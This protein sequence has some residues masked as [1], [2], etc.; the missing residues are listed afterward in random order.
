MILA[1]HQR[2][3]VGVDG[4]PNSAAAARWAANVAE[5][6]NAPLHIASAV[7]EPTFYIAESAMVIP[8]EVWE[9]QRH[10]ADKLVAD[11]S[12]A[13]Q[14]A[15]PSLSVTTGVDTTSAAVMLV[16]HSRTARVV[17]VGNS[18]TGLLVSTL[19]GS[20]AKRT[21]DK[22]DCPVV[23]WR[24]GDAAVDAPIVV[25]VD[26]SATSAAAVEYAF[27]LAAGLGLP[28]IAVHTWNAFSLGGGVALPG[29]VD[30]TTLE[31]EESALLSESLAGWSQKY[32]EVAVEHV[33]RQGS[34]A[35]L[36]VDLSRQSQLVVVGSRGRGSAAQALLGSTSSNLAHHAHC[37]VMICRGK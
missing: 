17:V 15:H 30:L 35:H 20:T 33:L 9:E 24:A 4:S 28:L 27:E 3:V 23:V 31:N 32:P 10:T 29:L 1:N 13:V 36:L 7:Q 14:E 16:E 22:A 5:R 2:V 19:L 18:G 8:A 12:T 34:A 26:G 25:G 21:V 6:L 11:L 37:P